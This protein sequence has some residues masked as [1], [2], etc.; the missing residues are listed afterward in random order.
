MFDK[1]K[2]AELLAGVWHP[3]STMPFKID[4]V[5][6]VEILKIGNFEFRKEAAFKSGLNWICRQENC[7]A[8]LQTSEYGLKL[9][10]NKHNHL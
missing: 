3:I 6:R 4:K 1:F 10:K 5:G 7:K 2:F 9:G 8:R